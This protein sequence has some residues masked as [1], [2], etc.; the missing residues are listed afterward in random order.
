MESVDDLKMI[1]EG[2]RPAKLFKVLDMSDEFYLFSQGVFGLYRHKKLG[3]FRATW[4]KVS[5][6]NPGYVLHEEN[7]SKLGAFQKAYIF[8]KNITIQKIIYLELNTSPLEV[9]LSENKEKIRAML[10]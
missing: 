5:E 2:A 7:L 1:I 6:S 4:L 8:K 9:S 10:E 3:I